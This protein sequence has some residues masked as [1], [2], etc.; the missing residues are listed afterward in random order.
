MQNNQIWPVRNSITCSTIW[1]KQNATKDFAKNEDNK[2]SQLELM[3][4]IWWL[5]Q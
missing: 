5:L 3:M 4:I 2:K 1:K